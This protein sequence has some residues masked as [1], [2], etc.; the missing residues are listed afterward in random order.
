MADT[1][2]SQTPEEIV[3]RDQN[4]RILW[5]QVEKN[6][7]DDQE[8]LVI[9]ACFVLDLKPREI[10][11]RNKAQFQDVR[12]VYRVKERVFTRLRGDQRL[13]ELFR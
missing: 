7:H 4:R 10:Y 6:L 2:A 13:A 8:R 3:M 11:A 1:P 5:Q 12:D 9:Y